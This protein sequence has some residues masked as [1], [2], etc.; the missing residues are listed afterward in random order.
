MFSVQVFPVGLCRRC[1]GAALLAAIVTLLIASFSSVAAAQT[2]P[3]AAPQL[4][5]LVHRI[6][7]YPDPLLAQVLTA[8][9]DWGEIPDE[10]IDEIFKSV[11]EFRGPMALFDDMTVAVLRVTSAA[12]G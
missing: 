8:S 9:T 2:V 5:H 10:L 1:F 11:A 3:L 12:L 4:D 7:L 6:A